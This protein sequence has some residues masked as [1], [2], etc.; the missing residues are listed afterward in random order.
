MQQPLACSIPPQPASSQL[1][2][3]EKGRG[4]FSPLAADMLPKPSFS[5]A[6]RNAERNRNQHPALEKS[7][8]DALRQTHIF[9]TE[10]HDMI[11]SRRTHLPAASVWEEKGKLPHESQKSPASLPDVAHICVSKKVICLVAWQSRSKWPTHITL[12]TRRQPETT[13][14]ITL[15]TKGAKRWF[16]F[17]HTHL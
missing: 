13:V 12:P 9:Q 17:N 7:H 15:I 16:D 8:D 4:D 3:L 1:L 11:M 10:S 6:Q 14:Q 2:C 5:P